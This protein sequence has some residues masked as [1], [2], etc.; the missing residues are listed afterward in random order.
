MPFC[1]HNILPVLFLLCQD[2]FPLPCIEAIFHRFEPYTAGTNP[3]VSTLFRLLHYSR[4][5]TSLIRDLV[6]LN[7][8]GTSYYILLSYHP[9]TVFSY[10][11]LFGFYGKCRY[12]IYHTWMLW[13][14]IIHG[15]RWK[16]SSAAKKNTDFTSW[17]DS[18]DTL[19]ASMISMKYMIKYGQN[20]S[21]IRYKHLQTMFRSNRYTVD[22]SR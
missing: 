8:S 4:L 22:A 1:L 15:I 17:I 5:Q 3:L 7:H 2:F 21:P 6:C 12:E 16:N 11:H 9:C 13:V 20:S 18:K 19:S 10:L 14:W